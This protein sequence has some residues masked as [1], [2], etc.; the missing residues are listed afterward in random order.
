M[1]FTKFT[2]AVISIALVLI[3]MSAALSRTLIPTHLEGRV[4]ARRPTGEWPNS[5]VDTWYVTIG[6][7]TYITSPEAAAVLTP[8]TRV[9]KPPWSRDLAGPDGLRLEA[10][11]DLLRLAGAYILV[12][13]T[14]LTLL[15]RPYRRSATPG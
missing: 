3:G 12:L 15:A 14:L 1:H 9:E 4:E 13:L 10:N 11:G 5:F 8:G 2:I 6:N 7:R